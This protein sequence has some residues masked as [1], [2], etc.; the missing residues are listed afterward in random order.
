MVMFRGYTTPV[1]GLVDSTYALT[2]LDGLG[3]VCVWQSGTC[4]ALIPNLGWIVRIV[5]ARWNRGY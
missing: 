5:F 2:W 1:H 3:R 4:F